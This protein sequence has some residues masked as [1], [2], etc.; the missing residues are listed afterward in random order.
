MVIGEIGHG[1]FCT[2]A[3]ALWCIVHGVAAALT[4]HALAGRQSVAAN[5]VLLGLPTE[6]WAHPL[7]QLATHFVCNRR[8][9]IQRLP[10][11]ETDAI[12]AL[13]TSKR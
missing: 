12:N 7:W 11:V 3:H 5:E 1:V 6:T 4:D 9:I 13:G 2:R 10:L 8:L